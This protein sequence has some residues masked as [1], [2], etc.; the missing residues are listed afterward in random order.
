[1]ALT[2]LLG[3]SGT[4]LFHATTRTMS[5]L[6]CFAGLMWC[7]V[8][9]DKP[10]GLSSARSAPLLAALAAFTVLT[11]TAAAA[12]PAGLLIALAVN[13]GRAGIIP[14][15]LALAASGAALAGWIWWASAH[16]PLPLPGERSATYFGDLRLKDLRDPGAGTASFT[17][18]ANRLRRN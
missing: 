17:D 1:L 12:L 4:I 6:P 14:P 11:R 7:L 18:Y 8:L 5:D 2:A 16:H 3:T 15:A 10:P 13:R 9:W